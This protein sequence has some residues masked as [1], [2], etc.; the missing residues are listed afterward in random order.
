MTTRLPASTGP[1][2]G[3]NRENGTVPRVEPEAA[4]A[5]GLD[6]HEY[7]VRRRD[8]RRTVVVQKLAVEQPAVEVDR[9]RPVDLA[10]RLCFYRR[11]PG[12]LRVVSV[13]GPSLYGLLTIGQYRR[14]VD[15]QGESHG[16]YRTAGG[17]FG[18]TFHINPL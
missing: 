7:G 13:G 6:G 11:Y 16:E 18:K 12:M 14:G 15:E 8:Q 17:S 10:H 2:L 5:T 4:E 3:R 9:R 1:K